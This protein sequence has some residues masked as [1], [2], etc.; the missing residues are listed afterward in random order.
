MGSY[1]SRASELDSSAVREVHH[2]KGAGKDR[3]GLSAILTQHLG[4]WA[5]RRQ[6]QAYSKGKTWLEKVYHDVERIVSCSHTDS[7]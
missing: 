7:Y 5:Q 4:T 1:Y 6:L 2:L 3:Q